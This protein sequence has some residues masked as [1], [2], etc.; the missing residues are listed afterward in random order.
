MNSRSKK[1]DHSPKNHRLPRVNDQIRDLLQE[2]FLHKYGSSMG[3]ISIVFVKTS[4]DLRLSHVYISS[5]PIGNNSLSSEKVIEILKKDSGKLR[6][7]LGK[8]LLIKYIPQLIFSSDHTLSDAQRVEE[9]INNISFR[10][11]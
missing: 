10:K 6:Y 3:L 8:K 7:L 5:V 2:I 1:S 9:L 11:K 4:P